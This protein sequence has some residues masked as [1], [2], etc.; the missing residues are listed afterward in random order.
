MCDLLY[1]VFCCILFENLNYLVC[2][3]FIDLVCVFVISF[4]N[5]I[6]IGFIFGDVVLFY[7]VG[8]VL[9]CFVV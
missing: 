3:V 9:M 8:L 4:Y 5:V 1:V 7:L 2:L 6:F